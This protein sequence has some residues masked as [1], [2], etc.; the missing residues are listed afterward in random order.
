MMS[1]PAAGN[2]FPRRSWRP[3]YNASDVDELIDRIEATLDGSAGPGQAVTGAD[4][5]AA[6]LRATRLRGY[7][8]LMVDD[9]LDAYAE[10]LESTGS[11]RR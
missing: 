10:Q 2:R 11:R 4:V 3:G 6:L 7:D 5:R 9:A 8:E 1:Q